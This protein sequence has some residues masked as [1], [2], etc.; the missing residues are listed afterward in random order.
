MQLRGC[1]LDYV[2][3]TKKP[4][5]GILDVER[6]QFI[7]FRRSQIIFTARCYGSAVMPQYVVCPSPSV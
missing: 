5:M 4:Y 1:L 3:M 2:F 7:I 6:R